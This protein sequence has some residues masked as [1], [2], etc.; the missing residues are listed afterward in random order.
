MAD[1]KNTALVPHE[2]EP[3]LP[4]LVE[5]GT[6]GNFDDLMEDLQRRGQ[7]IQLAKYAVAHT[8]KDH[9]CEIHGEPY[10]KGH[11]A[12]WVARLIGIDYKPVI[13]PRG[14]REEHWDNLGVYYLWTFWIKAVL[15]RTG[16][17]IT[18]EG[19]CSSR[20]DFF[21]TWKDESGKKHWRELHEIDETDIKNT[22]YTN[23]VARAV[24]ALLGIGVM[25]K[26]EI[27]QLRG[28]ADAFKAGSGFGK[29]TDQKKTG[30][31]KSGSKPKPKSDE[32]PNAP[33]AQ[34]QNNGRFNKMKQVQE[35][36]KFL[37]NNR[38]CADTPTY[39]EFVASVLEAE[40]CQYDDLGEPKVI[41]GWDKADVDA[42]WAAAKKRVEE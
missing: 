36:K 10:L 19:S 35:L 11:G 5:G 1:E 4:E 16:D 17:T 3:Q 29:K 41:E 2:G 39:R 14:V 27:N 25:S 32:H 15:K 8:T 9:W 31:K 28:T 21:A 40:K 22:A 7:L 33:P 12:R 42:L 30:G 37:M 24:K 6:L 18:E 20:D 34:A 23:A 26:Q 38:V 13:E